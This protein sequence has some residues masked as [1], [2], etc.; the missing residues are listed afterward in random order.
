MS[1]VSS[2][3]EAQQKIYSDDKLPTYSS[4]GYLFHLEIEQSTWS[5]GGCTKNS[6][7]SKFPKN[8][9]VLLNSG[10]VALN[11]L[12]PGKYKTTITNAMIMGA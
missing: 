11:A 5:A 7:A 6:S 3:T 8:V 1:D 9:V 12:T 4:I 10:A 2:S